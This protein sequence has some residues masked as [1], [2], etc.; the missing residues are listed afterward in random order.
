MKYPEVNSFESEGAEI[1]V[2]CLVVHTVHRTNASWLGNTRWVV[3]LITGHWSRSVFFT[4]FLTLPWIF[5][6]ILDKLVHARMQPI[7]CEQDT[8]Y[9]WRGSALEW[10]HAE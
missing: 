4:R 8:T 6:R 1:V 3:H 5:V 7:E 2:K 9:P 10:G